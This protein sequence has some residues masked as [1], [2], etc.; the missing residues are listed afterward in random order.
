M[1]IEYDLYLSN[2]MKPEQLM[3]MLLGRIEELAWAE[4][5]SFLTGPT[6]SVGTYE[7]RKSRQEAMEAGY[8]FA[9]ALLIWFRRKFDAK[10]GRFAELLLEITLLM[11]EHTQDAVL[12]FNGEIT[13]MQRLGGRI[14]FN[15]ETNPGRDEAWLRSHFPLPFECRPLPSPL[16]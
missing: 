11:L 4:D 7:P 2:N 8:G 5:K 9:P 6:M 3:E 13:V 16:L 10:P 14:A 12:L 15:A 1:A